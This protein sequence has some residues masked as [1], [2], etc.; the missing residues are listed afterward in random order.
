M[1]IIQLKK[2]GM[3]ANNKLLVLII[4]S[5][6]NKKSPKLGVQTSAKCCILQSTLK[7]AGKLL[8]KKLER[9]DK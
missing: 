5:Q 4:K 2:G 3:T 7:I 9:L 8:V 6:L 1:D